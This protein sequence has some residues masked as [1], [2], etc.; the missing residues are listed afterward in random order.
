MLISHVY[1]L[2]PLPA[3]P[4]SFGLLHEGKNR[5]RKHHSFSNGK[6]FMFLQF[7]KSRQFEATTHAAN[8]VSLFVFH[9]NLQ[10]CVWQ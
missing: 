10:I 8:T 4:R 1:N 5:K 9:V 6:P 3:S 2:A 7:G